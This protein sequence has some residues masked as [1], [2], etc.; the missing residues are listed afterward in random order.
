[1]G[2]LSAYIPMDRRQALARGATL[3]ERA[4]GAAL[5]C[6]I[7]GFT[8]LAEALVR[9]LGPRRAA[10][11]LIRCLNDV[12]E[13]LIDVVH[14]RGGS[15]VGFSGDAIT[16]WFD[17]D[18][19]CRAVACGLAMQTALARFA[20][21]PI[22]TGETVTLAGKVAIAVGPARRF[23]IGDPDIMLID[24][25]AGQTLQRMSVGEHLAEKG[26]VLLDEGFDL[27]LGQILDAAEW[28]VDA[29]T[30]R[31]Y[32]VVRDLEAAPPEVDWPPISADGAADDSARQWMARPV[33]ERLSTGRDTFLAELRPAVAL[34]MSFAGFDYDG[35]VNAPGKLDAYVRRVQQIVAR[36][37]GHLVQLT[38]GDKGSYLYASFGALVAHGDDAARAVAAAL[39]A[40]S[41]GQD[42]EYVEQ[43]R[44]GVT[45]GRVFC[46]AY[47]SSSCRTYG[48]QGDSVNLAARLMQAAPFGSVLASEAVYQAAM[49]SFTWKECP[50]IRVKGKSE[51]VTVWR[52][53]GRRA[54]GTVNEQARREI[55]PFVGRGAELL[56]I[57]QNVREVVSGESR[58]IAFIADAGMGKSRLV[59][60]AMRFWRSNSDEVYVG[61]CESYAAA[62]SYHVWHGILRSFFG[63]DGLDVLEDQIQ[64]L[65]RYVGDIDT[66]LIPRVPLL[67][68]A[69]NLPIPDTNLTESLDAKLRKASLEALLV[70]CIRARARASPLLLV[71]EDCHWL[72]SLSRDMLEAVVRGMAGRPVLVIVSY[73]PAQRGEHSLEQFSRLPQW[74]GIELTSLTEPETEQLIALKVEKLWGTQ[75]EPALSLV[76]RVGQLAQGNPFYVEE[77]LNYIYE[78]GLDPAD[79]ESLESVDL[80]SSLDSLI[81]SRVDQLTETQR[82]AIKVASVIGRQFRTRWLWGAD[83]EIGPEKQVIADLDVLHRLDLTLLEQPEPERTYLFKHVLTRDVA[84]GSVPFGTRMGLH[85]RLG[86]FIE[87]TYDE[88]LSEYVDLLA[89]HYDLSENESKKRE[90]LEKAGEAAQA[91]FA[92]EAAADY[93]RRLL[94]LVSGTE[95]IE[96]LT[97]LGQVLDLIGEWDEASEF[98]RQALEHAEQAGEVHRAATCRRAMGW[99]RRKQ[100]Q[101]GEAADLLRRARAG[102]EQ[103]DDRSALSQVATELGELSRTT[104]DYS[105][106]KRWYDNALRLAASVSTSEQ[107]LMAEAQ[108]LKGAGTL[109]A[110]Q[111]DNTAARALYEDSLSIRRELNDRPGVG[112]LLS[113][114]G[115]LAYYGGDY[116]AARALDEESL[117]LFHEIGDRWSAATLLNNLGD[118]ARDEGDFP[119]ARRLLGESLVIRR[120]LGDLGGIAFSLNSLGD[121]LLDEGDLVAALPVL[122]E[123]LSINRTLGDRAAMAYLLDDIAGLVAALGRA[124]DA[125][126]LAGAAEAAREMIG[127]QVAAGEQERFDRLLAPARQALSE[128]LGRAAF[129]AGRALTLEQAVDLALDITQGARPEQADVMPAAT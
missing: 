19:G 93:Y 12:Y 85:G 83:P 4:K 82:V 75:E 123:S 110:Q 50:A 43:V 78:R 34:F 129:E 74:S 116:A 41:I 70:D 68:G 108:A 99:L 15:V 9:G 104:G 61:E 39:E 37:G 66:A 11:E 25:L 10:E 111:G 33:F 49:Q 16:C 58:I 52:P 92:N 81:L 113:N 71:F 13:P 55:A 119:R 38:V 121:V 3:P 125:L 84:Y 53:V 18:N 94:P 117:A 88:S 45:A 64:A 27:G 79:A 42:L 59:S 118:I 56:A 65:E 30:G 90:Y 87:N 51:P 106:A 32:A 102:F 67:G 29:E 6:D 76:G 91:V 21:M 1:M 44:I 101:Y 80:P 54:R 120:R 40:Q 57:E 60:Q 28:R 86:Q 89:Y 128:P 103:L 98:Y 47:G 22:P 48:V 14:R 36:H 114:L 69:L 127:S 62:N 105:E 109:A 77:L 100:G 2:S 46:G 35:D 122:I 73:R 95:Q 63:L 72:D 126:R 124:E 5:F 31:R 23:V 112:A 17:E 20:A 26:E 107:R 24:V 115:V 8:P 7:S 96:V 97:R